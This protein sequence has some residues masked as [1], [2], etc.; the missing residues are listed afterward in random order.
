V[1]DPTGVPGIKKNLAKL[2][3]FLFTALVMGLLGGLYS[4]IFAG[5][6]GG[7][8]LGL[9]PK[10]SFELVGSYVCPEGTQLQYTSGQNAASGDS[11][12]VDCISQDGTRI[13]GQKPRAVSAVIGGYFLICFIP[14]YFPGAVL[15]WIFLNR[16]FSKFFDESPIPVDEEDAEY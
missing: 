14:T 13:Q 6:A 12:L 10:F 11:A 4:I 5:L 2:L 15:L 16:E 1:S 9:A 7:T 3:L 8:A